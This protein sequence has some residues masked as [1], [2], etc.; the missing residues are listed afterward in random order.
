MKPAKAVLVAMDAA[1]ELIETVEE[2][3]ARDDDDAE[4]GASKK[5]KEVKDLESLLNMI[6]TVM[7]SGENPSLI[8]HG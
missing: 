1:G 7:K 6:L 8:S 3:S 4:D 2:M 5:K